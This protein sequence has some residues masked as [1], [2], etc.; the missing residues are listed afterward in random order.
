MMKMSVFQ[1]TSK[2]TSLADLLP[3]HLRMCV[4]NIVQYCSTVSCDRRHPYFTELRFSEHRVLPSKD[5]NSSKIVYSTSTAK[6]RAKSVLSSNKKQTQVSRWPVFTELGRRF[7][8]TIKPPCN[9]NV[10]VFLIIVSS[11]PPPPPPRAPP[12]P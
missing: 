4:M 11:H 2:H 3:K 6:R 8:G 9:I 1:W 7:T 12:A 10:F 5:S